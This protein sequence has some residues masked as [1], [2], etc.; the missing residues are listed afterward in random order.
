M[1]RS[2]AARVFYLSLVCAFPVGLPA[3]SAYAPIASPLRSRCTLSASA[4]QL[5]LWRR[6]GPGGALHVAAPLGDFCALRALTTTGEFRPMTCERLASERYREVTRFYKDN[7]YKAVAKP[8]DILWVLRD[9][10]SESLVGAV[11]LSPQR[12]GP[13]GDLLFLRS[14]CIA[15]AWRRQGLG[16]KLTRA[17][18]G[19]PNGT[20]HQKKKQEEEGNVREVFNSAIPL[21]RYCFALTELVPLYVK[22]GWRLT[23]SDA[24]PRTISDR[25]A[26]VVAQTARKGKSVALL[27][28]GL[29]IA[30][31]TQSEHSAASH[32]TQRTLTRIALLQHANE[33]GRETATGTVLGHESLS[34]HI[35]LEKWVWRG[36]AD[37]DNISSLVASRS[38]VLVWAEEAP[39]QT[40]QTK[41]QSNDDQWYVIID[42]TWQEARAI[43]RKCC[44]LHA[45]P[46]VSLESARSSYR[47][48]KSVV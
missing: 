31:E 30:A 5:P 16:T 11:R 19:E 37:N 40:A 13:L 48:R 6:Q 32:T 29:P 45:L 10:S 42:G 28:H 21:P 47:D 8:T 33:V 23:P 34:P 38:C 18:I 4:L 26:A 43:F 46:R 27:S 39:G 44:A 2:D 41:S 1:G 20:L 17:A 3:H 35:E 24:M 12:Y 7:A 36:R 15:Q 14:L 9:P 22:A 25:F